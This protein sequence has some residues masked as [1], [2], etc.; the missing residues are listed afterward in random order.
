MAAR[1]TTFTFNLRLA[2][3]TAQELTFTLRGPGAGGLG[4]HGP[5]ERPGPGRERRRRRRRHGEHH[6]VTVKPGFG[7]G[8]GDYP[9]LVRRPSGDYSAQAQLVV[10]ITGSYSLHADAR[11]TAG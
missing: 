6:R 4:G 5:A 9:I 1:T 11:R 10:E 8:R 3:D 7:C 2:N